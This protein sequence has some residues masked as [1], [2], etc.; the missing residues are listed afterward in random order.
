MQ[1]DPSFFEANRESWNKRT[2]VHRDSAFYDLDGFKKGQSS[3]NKIEL[4]Q[5]GDVSGKTLL[6]LQCHFGLDTMSW[7]REG[8]IVTGVDLSDEAIKLA[9]TITDELQ[10]KAKS[11]ARTTLPGFRTPEAFFPNSPFTPSLLLALQL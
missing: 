8:A 7:E 5:L 10:L 4:E 1:T 9:N 6:H 11:L 3:L 2:M